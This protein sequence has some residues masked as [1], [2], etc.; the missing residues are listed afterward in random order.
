MPFIERSSTRPFLYGRV[1][2]VDSTQPIGMLTMTMD[3]DAFIK[4]WDGHINALI[5][6][7][8]KKPEKIEEKH[9]QIVAGALKVF[10][11]KG[12]HPTT[13]RE[14]AEAAG[15]SLG[16]LYHYVSSKD[17]VLFLIHRHQQ[18]AFYDH[19]LKIQE[20]ADDGDAIR[21]LIIS[22]R[23]ALPFL[24]RH[25]KLLRFILGESRYLNKKHLDVVL[26]M[27]DRN[28]VQYWRELLTAVKSQT[29]LPFNVDYTANL[30]TYLATFIPMRGWNLKDFATE[31]QQEMLI[32]AILSMM[33]V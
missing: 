30:I 25:R 11:S 29:G 15:M 12:Y 28:I 1:A 31:D 24:A 2:A 19:M 32:A 22:L 26:E 27:D 3:Y 14:I 10:L 23:H 33:G 6:V 4:R 9:Q 17:D 8:A 5:K 20:R 13:I 18:I 16:Q 21:S 7:S